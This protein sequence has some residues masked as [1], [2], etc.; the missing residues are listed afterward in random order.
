MNYAYIN[1]NDRPYMPVHHKLKIYKN[2]WSG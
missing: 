1:I 2:K